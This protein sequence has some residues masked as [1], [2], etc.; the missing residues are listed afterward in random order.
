L[1]PD[2]MRVRLHLRLV[3]V[4]A[5]IVGIFDEL[6]VEVGSTRSSS[7]CPFY[8]FSCRAVHDTRV[9][10][11]RDLPVSGRRTTLRWRRRRFACAN[12]GERHL[13]QHPVFE[14]RVTAR[15]AR[16]S[17]PTPR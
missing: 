13:E 3:R 11:V 1:A 7:T 10:R 17:S 12:C 4:L 5:V 2:T 16:R 6:E 15:L 8:G 9:Q 14:G